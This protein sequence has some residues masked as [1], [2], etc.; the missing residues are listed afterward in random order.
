MQ[1]S[2]QTFKF[3]KKKHVEKVVR[4][5]FMGK[6]IEY[7]LLLAFYLLCVFKVKEMKLRTIIRMNNYYAYRIISYQVFFIMDV[8]LQYVS[9]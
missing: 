7:I 8:V 3:N 9:I 4:N 5:I 1:V 2:V 6:N